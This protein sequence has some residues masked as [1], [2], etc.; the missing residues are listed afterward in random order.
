MHIEWI[1][2]LIN[3]GR[4]R[5]ALHYIEPRLRSARLKSAWFIRRARARLPL[6]QT[7]EAQHDLH[8][9]IAEITDR[10]QP[11]RP[12]PDL[13]IDRAIAYLL[14]GN[15]SAARRDKEQA[16]RHHVHAS[17]LRRLKRFN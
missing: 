5:E 10:M 12:N 8:L 7:V 13:L 14:L 11:S 9:A 15:V 6:G 4:A 3:A 16:Q 17:Q 2:A 1:D